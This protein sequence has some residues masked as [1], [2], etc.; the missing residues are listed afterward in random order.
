MSDHTSLEEAMSRFELAYRAS[1]EGLW[2]MAVVADDPINPQNEFWLSDRFRQ[3]LGFDSS[4]EFPNILSSWSSRLHP[5]DQQRVLAAFFDHLTDITGQTGYDIEYRL[6]VKTGEYR[7]FRTTGATNRNDK[8]VPLRVAGFLRDITE[9]RK[10][11]IVLKDAIDRFDLVNQASADGLWDMTINPENPLDAQ[12]RVWWSDRYREILGYDETS[13]PNMLSS[14]LDCI[15]AEDKDRV[16]SAFAAH[17]SNSAEDNKYNIEYRI[18]TQSGP[19]RWF[20]VLGATDRDNNG[21]PLRCAGCLKDIT[22]E[23]EQNNQIRNTLERF[24]LLNE[25]SPAPFWDM[26]VIAGDPVNPD[27]EFWWSDRFRNLLGYSNEEDFPNVLSSWSSR[28]HPDDHDWVIEAFSRHLEDKSG[29]TPYDVQYRLFLKDDSVRWFRATGITLR[30][31]MGMPLRVA[32]SLLDIDEERRIQQELSSTATKLEGLT[33]ELTVV[34]QGTKNDAESAGTQANEA[35]EQVGEVAKSVSGILTS[36]QELLQ[37]V[38][39]IGKSANEARDVANEAMDNSRR[40][41]Q[42]IKK[43]EQ[44]ST[45]IGKVVK[46]IT[47]IAEQTKLLALNA[48]IEA[49]RA[50]DTGKG[51]AV[52]AN[53]VKELAKETA[54]ATDEIAAQVAEIQSDTNAVMAVIFEIAKIT[55][56][57]CDMQSTISSAVEAY[58]KDSNE[59]IRLAEHSDEC[60][61]A[62][63][64]NIQELSARAQSTLKKGDSAHETARTLSEMASSLTQ[65][66]TS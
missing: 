14:W 41:D 7:W 30:N 66:I 33:R 48:T 55:T 45:E 13:F 64:K 35:S 24:Y 17:L 8:G 5:E 51:F 10:R 25:A 11:E 20:R 1:A 26:S 56:N 44:S 18:R 34:S 38:N 43:L 9:E 40:A 28:L 6:Q 36:T 46:L 63:A 31:S 2:D 50:G 37:T 19:Y 65:L 54:D 57:I 29:Q 58:G 15:H 23:R 12:N 16:L 42:T 27:N 61:R 60:V 49:A 22:Q 32:G 3:M 39:Q 21:A 59:I 4:D 52:V 47:S 53:E 62:F